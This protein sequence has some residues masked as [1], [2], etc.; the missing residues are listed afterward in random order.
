ME[1]PLTLALCANDKYAM[2]LAV[3]LYSALA[4]LP[5]GTPVTIYVVENG[6]TPSNKDKIAKVLARTA[7]VPIIHYLSPE[8][9]TFANLSTGTYS[10]EAMFRLALPTLLP[11]GVE[12]IIFLDCDL[13]IERSLLPLWGMSVSGTAA[14]ACRDYGLGFASSPIGP[15]SCYREL[16]LVDDMPCL[17]SGLMV[18]NVDFWRNHDVP[19]QVIDYTRRFA[20][21][22]LFAD[23][24]GINAV[25]AGDWRSLDPLWN[26]QISAVRAFDTWPAS[27]HKEGMR[28]LIDSLIPNAHVLHYT[29][30]RKPWDS[31]LFNPARGRFEHYLKASGWFSAPEYMEYRRRWLMSSLQNICRD[32]S[33]KLAGK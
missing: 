28:P 17:N 15:A 11:P 7:T 5:S 25:L 23:Q 32:I 6:I 18:I 26:V 21:R 22:V 4:N 13:I 27:A 9:E 12:R 3:T 33:R 10:V 24:D 30:G 14:L 2:P 31:G 1:S 8:A 29:G 20:G 16:G 19:G